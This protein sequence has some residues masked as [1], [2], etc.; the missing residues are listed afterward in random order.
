M[1]CVCVC[2]CVLYTASMLVLLLFYNLDPF[3]QLLHLV[4]H[5]HKK[6]IYYVSFVLYWCVGVARFENPF[7]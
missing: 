3:V 4:V 7:W 1:Y 6:H 2:V 5:L